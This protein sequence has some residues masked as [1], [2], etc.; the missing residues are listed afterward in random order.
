MANQHELDRL[1]QR[2]ASTD[3]TWQA[4]A[5]ALQAGVDFASAH[6]RMAKRFD[7]QPSLSV[8][9]KRLRADADCARDLALGYHLTGDA[10]LARRAIL[11]LE[12][13]T[14][15]DL[16]AAMAGRLSTDSRG[17]DAGARWDHTGVGV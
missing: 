5:A 11:I 6:R 16:D 13:W 8:F 17:D 12:T 14:E 9:Y 2:S 1:R 15:P 4:Y 7:D 3:P 10:A